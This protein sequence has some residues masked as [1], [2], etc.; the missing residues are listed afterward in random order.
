[1]KEQHRRRPNR[2]RS[3]KPGK[4]GFGDDGLDLKEEKCGK[5][6]ANGKRVH[7]VVLFFVII[8]DRRAEFC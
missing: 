7:G 6:D 5:Q 1:L 8:I 2:G 3:P 4:Q